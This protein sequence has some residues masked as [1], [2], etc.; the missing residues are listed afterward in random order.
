[1]I[2][3]RDKSQ[4]FLSNHLALFQC[5]VCES[6]F[7]RIEN[8]QLQCTGRHQFD[9]NKKGS[10]HLMM[11]SV[12]SEYTREML[13]SR[14]RIAQS[15]FWQPLLDSIVPLLK[16][17]K[18]PILDVGCGEGSHAAYLK[19]QGITSPLIAFD[20]SKEGVNLAAASYSDTF[21]L[22]ADL[23][24]SPFSSGQYATLLNIL[25]PSNYKEFKR[26]L[27]Q[28]G[29]VIKVVP[30]PDYLK[31]LRD[32]KE[33]S[34]EAY[35]NEEVVSKFEEHFSTVE[36]TRVRYSYRLPKEL[37]EDFINMT[38]LGWHLEKQ[39]N[40]IADELDEIT[41]DLTVLVGSNE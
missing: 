36:K 21:F 6:N 29:Q 19:N 40:N 14:Q 32:L 4:L 34:K 27:K 13:L 22:V 23:A 9:L 17:N 20:I 8:Y 31:E 38:P 28:N 1:M 39:L 12:E 15:G 35:S 24:H 2:K 16:G 3:K 25:S 10:L 7:E 5:P 18:G 11:K 26:V 37:R 33:S 30:N 41:I